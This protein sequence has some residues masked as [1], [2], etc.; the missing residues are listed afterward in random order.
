LSGLAEGDQIVIRT[1]SGLSQLQRAFQQGE[2]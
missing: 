1:Q 2:P